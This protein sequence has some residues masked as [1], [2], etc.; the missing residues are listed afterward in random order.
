MRTPRDW[1][2]NLPVSGHAKGRLLTRL[3]KVLGSAAMP[4]PFAS[5]EH[6]CV[7]RGRGQ[8]AHAERLE[9]YPR[10]LTQL[11]N[12]LES[13]GSRPP[14]TLKSVVRSKQEAHAKRMGLHPSRLR[15]RVVAS[16]AMTG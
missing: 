16:P 3:G 13:A 11:A 6:D 10:L 7:V 8:D 12:V 5:M 2:C 14:F 9:L 15:S 1:D 4:P